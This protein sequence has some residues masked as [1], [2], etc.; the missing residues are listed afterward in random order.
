MRKDLMRSAYAAVLILLGFV[1]SLMVTAPA[2][3]AE[4]DSLML[5]DTTV[6]SGKTVT[7]YGWDCPDRANVQLHLDGD[8]IEEVLADKD[9]RFEAKI[10]VG[11]KTRS[12]KHRL[13]ARCGK[14]LSRRAIF[15]VRTGIG[16]N[17]RLV[18][19][20]S[21]M[22]VVGDGCPQGSKAKVRVDGT[23]AAT[24]PVASSG[25]FSS[26]ITVSPQAQRGSSFF[27]TAQCGNRF[28]GSALVRVMKPFPL[29]ERDF[30]LISRTAVQAGQAVNLFFED[31]PDQAPTALLDGKRLTLTVDRT[32]RGGFIARAVIPRKTVPGRYQLSAGCD[33]ET[34]GNTEIQVLDPASPEAVT[35][36]NAF[37]VKTGSDLAVWAGALVGVALLVASVSVNWR[38]RA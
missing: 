11:A 38:G 28:A 16:V 3:A 20:G 5:S 37:G 12:G 30:V 13:S 14:E 21:R 32:D 34:P 35:T 36:R 10:T 22:T 8:L 23:S 26:T 15:V 1:A 18:L 4:S 25:R 7:A 31:C 17:P 2:W 33:V 19:P 27:V 6:H 24:V 9:G 29:Y